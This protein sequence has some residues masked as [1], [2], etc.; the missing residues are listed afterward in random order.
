MREITDEEIIKAI[1]NLKANKAAGPN[2]FPLEWYKVIKDLLIPLM[3]NTY[4][5][6]I[7]TAITPPSLRDA[8]ISLIPKQGKDKMECGSYRPVSILNS[9]YKIFTH[10][11]AKRLKKILPQIVSLVQTGFIQQRHTQD[12]ICRTL[13]VM[14]KKKKNKLQA[15]LLSLNAEKALDRV[16]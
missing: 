9:D 6:D 13:H 3:K 1:S 8:V 14:E 11:L 10:I 16:S 5:H 12:Y 7:K 15:V 2:G 4:N